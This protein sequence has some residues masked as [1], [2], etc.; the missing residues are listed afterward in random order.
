MPSPVGEG[1]VGRR[2]VGAREGVRVVEGADP[3]D[4]SE[5]KRREKAF[6][7]AKRGEKVKY[8]TLSNVK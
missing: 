4:G 8:S 5:R 1:K 3:Y 7:K 2:N 6:A